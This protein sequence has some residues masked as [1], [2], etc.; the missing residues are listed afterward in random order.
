MKTN[1]NNF[2]YGLE[3]KFSFR[4]IDAALAL[5]KNY[6]EDRLEPFPGA[7]NRTGTFRLE[8]FEINAPE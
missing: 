5:M 8:F 4:E 7:E 6:L 1:P 2:K 3:L